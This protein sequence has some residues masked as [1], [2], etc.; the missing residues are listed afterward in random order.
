MPYRVKG[1]R[2]ERDEKSKEQEWE[3]INIIIQNK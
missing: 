2:V 1:R 3:K